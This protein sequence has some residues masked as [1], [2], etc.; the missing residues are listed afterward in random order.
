MQHASFMLK[1]QRPPS[2]TTKLYYRKD[3]HA[4]RFCC[5]I[6]MQYRYDPAIKVR[7]SDVKRGRGR[8]RAETTD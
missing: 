2:I 1:S 3:Y 4:M 6:L 5:P 8:R 7:S